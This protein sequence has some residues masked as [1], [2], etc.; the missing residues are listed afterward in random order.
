VQLRK[1]FTS[2][3]VIGRTLLREGRAAPAQVRL[4]ARRSLLKAL[5]GD[6]VAAEKAN[7]GSV[8]PALVELLYEGFHGIPKLNGGRLVSAWPSFARDVSGPRERL[9]RALGAPLLSAKELTVALHALEPLDLR[10]YT[11]ESLLAKLLSESLPFFAAW[12]GEDPGD[13]LA[14]LNERF[15]AYQAPLDA[16]DPHLGQAPPFATTYGPSVYRCVCGQAFGDP[17]R[18]LTPEAL[19]ALATARTQ[20]F[21]AVYRARG[22]DG[23]YPG[24]G[25]LHYNLHRAV[26]RVV[27]EQFPRATDF[28]EGMVPAVAAYLRHDAKGFLSDPL[29]ESLLRPALESYLAL[30][31]AGQPH[32]E[33]VLT[34]EVKAERERRL[35]HG[36]R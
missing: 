5:V 4:V 28:A 26:Q 19:R 34:L 7:P 3:G 33:G 20:H 23:W 17:V 6:A 2:A 32:P 21:R 12:H 22:G 27:K 1:S 14:L 9:E 36:A 31:R 30:R 10:Q 8:R 16:S 35:L 24:E 15:A 11:A 25:T 18:A 29:L 13:V